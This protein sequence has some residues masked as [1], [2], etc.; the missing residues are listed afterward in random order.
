MSLALYPSRVR[1]NDLLGRIFGAL[2]HVSMQFRNT[3]VADCRRF[4]RYE[5]LD[6]GPLL[7]TKGAR[8]YGWRFVAKEVLCL[9]FLRE[10][11]DESISTLLHLV[12]Q[13]GPLKMLEKFALVLAR[14]RPAEVPLE[15]AITDSMRNRVHVTPEI[16]VAFNEAVRRHKS[17]ETSLLQAG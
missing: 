10:E 7:S 8:L 12:P 11:E 4:R 16:V 13:S 15:T 17:L 6:L 2:E 1:S 3:F 9:V 14:V 5:S